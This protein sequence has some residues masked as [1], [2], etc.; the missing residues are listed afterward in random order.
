VQQQGSRPPDEEEEANLEK[1]KIW[2]KR[3]Y[4]FLSIS[5]WWLVGAA[6]FMLT[7]GWSYLDSFYFAFVTLSTIG[8]GDFYPTSSIGMNF[9]IFYSLTGLGIFAFALSTLAESSDDLTGQMQ[10]LKNTMNMEKLKGTS[11]R[12]S[13]FAK[14]LVG[15]EHST[16]GKSKPKEKGVEARKPSAASPKPSLPAKK[17]KPESKFVVLDKEEFDKYSNRLIRAL[18]RLQACEESDFQAWM[19]DYMGNKGQFEATFIEENAGAKKL[20]KNLGSLNLLPGEGFEKKKK[21]KPGAQR[22]KNTA[23]PDESPDLLQL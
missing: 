11:D 7:E 20:R 6:I 10:E 12:V 1:I 8:Y 15:R 22:K 23:D 19:Q 14:K 5:G 13:G 3:G 18:K 9:L 17:K 21:T 16:G 4:V 2:K